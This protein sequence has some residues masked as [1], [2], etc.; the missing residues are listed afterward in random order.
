MGKQEFQNYNYD[1]K[2]AGKQDFLEVATTW[3]FYV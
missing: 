2:R 3:F 1:I